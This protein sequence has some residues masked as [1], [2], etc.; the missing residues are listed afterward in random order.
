MPDNHKDGLPFNLPSEILFQETGGGFIYSMIIASVPAD[1]NYIRGSPSEV[2]R[3][4]VRSGIRYQ[5][6]AKTI[7]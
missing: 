3:E 6:S 7:L 4:G 1:C 2:A 5:V